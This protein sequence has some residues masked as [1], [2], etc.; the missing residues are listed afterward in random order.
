MTIDQAPAARD[1]RAEQKSSAK[2]KLCFISQYGKYR[3]NAVRR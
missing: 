2:K 3:I 1:R